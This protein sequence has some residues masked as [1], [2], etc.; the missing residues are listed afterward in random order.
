MGGTPGVAIPMFDGQMIFIRA[1][2]NRRIVI[3]DMITT[4]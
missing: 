1:T 4:V 2:K 3:D